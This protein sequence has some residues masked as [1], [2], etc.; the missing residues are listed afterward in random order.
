MP[1]RARESIY[2][3][4]HL[5]TLELILSTKLFIQLVKMLKQYLAEP[6]FHLVNKS[7]LAGYLIFNCYCKWHILPN[8]KISLIFDIQPGLSLGCYHPSFS[9]ERYLWCFNN[10]YFC[11]V[12][13]FV[14]L[15][16]LNMILWWQVII[17]RPAGETIKHEQNTNNTSLL[18]GG[19]KKGTS[20]RDPYFFFTWIMFCKMITYTIMFL[21]EM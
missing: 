18:Q 16:P 21:Y 5:P 19:E 2:K 15:C 14:L 7:I 11:V 13:H 10:L 6:P 3:T 17:A 4:F 20:I 1:V 12:S 8:S 9:L